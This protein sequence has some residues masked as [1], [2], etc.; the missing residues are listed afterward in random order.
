MAGP[1]VRALAQKKKA[2]LLP[3][4]SEH[5]AIFNLLEAHGRE[6]LAELLLTASGGPFRNHTQAQLATVRAQDALKHPTWDMGAKITIDSA[7]M[8]NKGLEV[9][10]AARLFD[11]PPEKIRVVVHPQ[12]IVHSM[13]SFADGSVYAQLSRPDMRL[14]IQNALY[15]P[16]NAPAGFERL[17]FD[18]LTLTFEKPDIT[19][20]PL[21]PLAY[22]ALRA[23]PLYPVVYNAANEIAVAAFLAERIAFP[24]IARIVRATLERDWTGTLSIESVR[25][26]DA[27]AR[28]VARLAVA[29]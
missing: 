26:T 3:V 28:E 25:D 12:S 20:F 7:S 8:A 14:P 4:D 9:I 29:D 6:S 17:S 21:L 16:R 11:V 15:Y 24:D 22:E 5:S 10:E 23:G 27:R 1:L 2:L 19:K 18:Q 13:I